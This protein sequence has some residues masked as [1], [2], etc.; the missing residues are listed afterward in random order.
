MH[1][2]VAL[3]YHAIGGTRKPMTDIEDTAVIERLLA[4]LGRKLE[5]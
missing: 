3:P 4:R 1:W 2:V 5:R